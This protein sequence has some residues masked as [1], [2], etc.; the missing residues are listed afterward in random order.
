MLQIIQ[1]DRNP[2]K[3][4]SASKCVVAK[5]NVENR[6]KNLNFEVIKDS[7]ALIAVL[8]LP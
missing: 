1:S 3:E 8:K 6:V 7:N 5:H 2:S 4:L